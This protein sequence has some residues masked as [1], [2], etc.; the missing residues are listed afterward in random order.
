MLLPGII[1]HHRKSKEGDTFQR[2]KPIFRRLKSFAKTISF[3]KELEDRP[4]CKRKEQRKENR[5]R[6]VTLPKKK[7]QNA[8]WSARK[9]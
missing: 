1:T 7:S 9:E 6:N 3:A 4:Q 2:N 5:E 8:S